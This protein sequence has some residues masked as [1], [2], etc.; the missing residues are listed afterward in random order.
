MTIEIRQL[1]IRST[2]VERE[3]TRP[4]PSGETM[5]ETA[6]KRELLQACK[7]LIMEILETQR[8]R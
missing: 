4:E 2:I 6:L 1:N 8:E 5:N 3:E 7:H